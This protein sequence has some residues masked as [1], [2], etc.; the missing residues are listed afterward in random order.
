ME[1]IQEGKHFNLLGEQ[2]KNTHK[3]NTY[4]LVY[5]LSYYRL[6]EPML[7]W[8]ER[9]GQNVHTYT[10]I[11]SQ[12]TFFLIT[13]GIWNLCKRIYDTPLEAMFFSLQTTFL[14]H[15]HVCSYDIVIRFSSILFHIG[16]DSHKRLGAGIFCHDL[17]MHTAWL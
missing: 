11:H 5:T 15:E 6:T 17:T 4:I 8:Y 12:I 1:S 2:G 14:S 9:N 13:N 3:A 16:K 7:K 10:Y